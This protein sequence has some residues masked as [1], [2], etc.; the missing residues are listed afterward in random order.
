[1]K[2]VFDC[3]RFAQ[4]PEKFRQYVLENPDFES[5]EEDAYDVIARYTN[6]LKHTELSAESKLEGE[7]VNMCKAMDV[8]M[9]E[10]EAVG[11][12]EGR[13]E[14]I[15]D[16]LRR[17]GDLSEALV[18]HIMGERDTEVL[19]EWASLAVRSASIQEFEAAIYGH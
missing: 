8:L 3:I 11:K 6:V 18:Q 13:A 1:M 17:I 10:R 7:K 5:I 12:A 14:L 2:L 15:L 9:A 4:D 19:C 16:L